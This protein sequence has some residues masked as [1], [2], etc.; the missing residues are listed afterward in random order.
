MATL[1][2]LE[3]HDHTWKC[4]TAL[5]EAC[6]ASLRSGASGYS[7]KCQLGEAWALTGTLLWLWPRR[8]CCLVFTSSASSRLQRAATCVPTLRDL[9]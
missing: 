4:V 2:Q 5:K 6:S 8:G 1:D 3:K 9:T 7:R